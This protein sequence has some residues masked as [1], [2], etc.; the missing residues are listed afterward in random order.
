MSIFQI[1]SPL[2]E[3]HYH[4]GKEENIRIFIKRDDLIHQDISG[5]KWRKLKYNIEIAIEQKFE[6]I[7]SWGGAWSN[8]LAA[9]AAAGEMFNIK[10]IGIIRGEEPK[11]WSHTLIYCKQ[12]GMELHFISRSNFEELPHSANPILAKHKNTFIIPV[13]G[14]GDLGV[15]GCSEIL[16]EIDIPYQLVCT[17]VGT[18]TTLKG[19]AGSNKNVEF[20]G[21]SALKESSQH[22]FEFNRWLDFQHHVE[23]THE[24]SM[25]GFAKSNKILEDFIVDFYQQNKIMLEPVYTGKMMYGVFDKVKKQQI[26]PHTNIVCIHTGGLQ[27][28]TGFPDLHKRL[29]TS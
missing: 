5:N 29:F 2:H 10:T 6:A 22:S 14:E 1:P 24:Y 26:K 11:V 20:I 23:L 8:H 19:L 13:G 18:G 17:P 12:K 28:L 4:P 15:H 16:N 7:V 9:L 27:G 25:G 21:F 3:I